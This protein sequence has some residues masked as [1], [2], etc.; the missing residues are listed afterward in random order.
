MSDI[1]QLGDIL[2]YRLVQFRKRIV[3]D[4]LHQ[5][6]DTIWKGE[7]DGDYFMFIAS[8][9]FQIIS[10]SR[11]D[12]QT[13]R[14]WLR[15]AK[16][17]A[18]ADRSG[19]MVFAMQDMLDRA[20]PKFHAALDEW[21]KMVDSTPQKDWPRVSDYR[22]KPPAAWMIDDQIYPA[23][24]E[25]DARQHYRDLIDSGETDVELIPLYK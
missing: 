15:G 12:V 7:D 17:D 4:I 25:A 20:Y 11:M 23:R 10:R 14:L 24:Y 8:N 9:D 16:N 19:T 21:A 13:E 22:P 2:A 6:E 5:R 18:H 3:F 1:I